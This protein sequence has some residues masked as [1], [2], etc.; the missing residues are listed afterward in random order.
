MKLGSPNE[1]T[2]QLEWE[3][4]WEMTKRK[5]E[6]EVLPFKYGSHPWDKTYGF[7]AKV[8]DHLFA[9]GWRLR[10]WMALLVEGFNYEWG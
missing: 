1:K 7:E 4:E 9:Q 3:L 6:K 2:F 10:F 5:N 8:M